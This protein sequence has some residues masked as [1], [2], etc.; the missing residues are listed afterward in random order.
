MSEIDL[1]NT[2]TWKPKKKY[3]NSGRDPRNTL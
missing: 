3:V 2:K 1:I